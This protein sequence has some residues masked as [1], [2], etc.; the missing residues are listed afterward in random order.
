MFLEAGGAVSVVTHE[1]GTRVGDCV[2]VEPR[3][4]NNTRWVSD[5]ACN[6]DTNEVYDKHREDAYAC[7]AAKK[8]LPDAEDDAIIE[9]AARTVS[10]LLTP[11]LRAG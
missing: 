11:D 3:D 4:Y 7:L 1:G 6:G 2:A 8:E 10:V 9:R 5:I